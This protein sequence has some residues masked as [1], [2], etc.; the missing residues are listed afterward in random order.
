M[1]KELKRIMKEDK[2]KTLSTAASL[3][4]LAE[5]Q[6]KAQAPEAGSSRTDVET[7]RLLHEL[8]V[9]HI[10]LEMMNEELRHAREEAEIALEKYSGLFDFSPI[11]YLTLDRK[12]TICDV[13]LTGA[14]LLRVER[15]RLPGRDFKLFV[16]DE[17][18]PCFTDFIGKVFASHDK[19]ACEITLTT[20]GNS[21]LNVQIEAIA[22]IS[23]P[24]CRVAVIDITARRSAEDA[25]AKKRHK[26]EELNRSLETRIVQAVTDLREKDQM[27]ILQDRM[28]VMGEMINNIAHQWRQP[29]NNLGMVIQQLPLY[30]DTT[31]FNREFLLGNTAKA[32]ELIRHMSRTIDDFRNFFRIDKQMVSFNVRQVIEQ[33]VSLVEKSFQNERVS[34]IIEV[35]GEPTV[36]GYPNEYAQVLLNILTNARDALVGNNIEDARISIQ[37][38]AEKDSTVVLITDNAGGIAEGIMDKLF[39]PYFTTKG[40]DNGTGIGL[41]MSKTIIEKNMG[42][43]LRVRNTGSGAEFRIEV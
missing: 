6:L 10:E 13:N 4:H 19:E 31:E 8:Q 33:S 35:T 40:P 26:L 16:V 41:F 32:M 42:G 24:E 25:L 11:S 15:L 14:G 30:Y 3:R 29:L 21:R 43:H 1:K 20:A 37:T 38:F 12:G 17:D 5:E 9:H 39:D 18:R 2:D 36:Y 34:I 27:L 22:D 28:A 23:E 7:L